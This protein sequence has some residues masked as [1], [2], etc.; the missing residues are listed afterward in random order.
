[1]GRIINEMGGSNT[2]HY[3]FVKNYWI[4]KLGG[5]S[6]FDVAIQKGIL[7]PETMP[8]SGAFSGNVADAQAKIATYKASADGQPELVIYEKIGIGRGGVGVIIHGCRKC[9][10]QSR[11]VLGTIM[12]S[13]L[14]IE[15]KKWVLSIDRFK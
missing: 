10:I 3:D 1:M 15:L 6:A 5:E 11:N 9:L 12:Y 13:C 7:E 4:A 14:L 2:S 8:M